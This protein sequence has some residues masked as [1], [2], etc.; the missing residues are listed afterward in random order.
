MSHVV[1]DGGGGDGGWGQGGGK[2]RIPL[3]AYYT[4]LTYL[5]SSTGQDVIIGIPAEQL[6]MASLGRERMDKK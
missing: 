4:L 6:R 3:G 5:T 1:I 2:W